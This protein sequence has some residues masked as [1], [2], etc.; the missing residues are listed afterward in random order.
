MLL[1]FRLAQPRTTPQEIL[2]DLCTVVVGGKGVRTHFEAHG[3]KLHGLNHRP[4]EIL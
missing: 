1:G 4:R 3:L 2:E